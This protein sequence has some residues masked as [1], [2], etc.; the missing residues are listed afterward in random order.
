MG[1]SGVTTF[2]HLYIYFIRSSE[3]HKLTIFTVKCKHFVI[4][5]PSHQWHRITQNDATELTYEMWERNFL[6]NFDTNM[7]LFLLLEG[8]SVICVAFQP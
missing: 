1:A 2:S 5:S 7:Q 6:P 3:H 4:Y 8:E